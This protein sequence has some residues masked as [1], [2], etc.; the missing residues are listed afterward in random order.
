MDST[1]GKARSVARLLWAAG[2]LVLM[3]LVSCGGR[4]PVP[5]EVHLVLLHTNDVHGQVLPRPATWLEIPDPPRMGGIKRLDAA[6]R[7]ER[8]AAREQG[9]EVLLVDGGDWTQGTPEGRLN[10]G[11]DA[12]ALMVQMGYDGMA[13]GNHEFDHGLD[14]FL[15]HLE[16]IQPPALLANALTTEGQAL[17]GLATHRVIERAG[18]SI[19]LVGL[20]TQDAP[21][22]THASVQSLD[23]Q[24]PALA[25]GR[26][27]KEFEGTPSLV[28]PLTHLGEDADRALAR[29]HPGLPLII[30]GHSHTKLPAG[31]REGNTLIVQTGAKATY[32]GRVDLW[33]DSTSH[34]VL[35]SEARL[36]DLDQPVLDHDVAFEEA[37]DRLIEESERRMGGAV[38]VL[39]APLR[40]SKSPLKTSGSGNLLT[41][42]MAKHAGAQISFH[43]RGGLRADLAAGEVTRRSLFRVLPFENHMVSMDLSGAQ[44]LSLLAAS[45]GRMG[46]SPLEFSGLE[47]FVTEG[48]GAKDHTLVR[49]LVDGEALDEERSYRVV[50]NSFLAEGGDGYETFTQGVNRQVDPILLRDLLEGVFGNEPVHPPMDS[51]LMTDS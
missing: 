34:V 45:I 40:R 19:V 42:V 50:T 28:I 32:L 1:L 20:L 44:V 35:R 22:L 36:I 26:I 11:R 46:H 8:Q 49:V 4:E 14:V 9:A 47:V 12:A 30:G 15:E 16:V 7:L 2:G 13:V 25:L 3:G 33:V 43:N 24:S 27:R 5:Q 37:C 18:L 38:G 23:W 6:I 21:T 17:P 10:H 48:R 51:R 39:A 41:D 29:A 31:V